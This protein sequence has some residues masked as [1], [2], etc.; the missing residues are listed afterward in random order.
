MSIHIMIFF[1]FRRNGKDAAHASRGVS[2]AI[3]ANVRSGLRPSRGKSYM[4]RGFTPENPSRA[5][6]CTCKGAK[7]P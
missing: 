1:D 3:A 4:F 6:P 5:P 7:P 2:E